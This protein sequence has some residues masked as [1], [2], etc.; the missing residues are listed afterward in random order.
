MTQTIVITSGKRGVGKTY[1]SVNTAI[2]L[3]RR[4]YRTCLFDADMGLANVNILL[5]IN[6]EYSFDDY[7]FG[8]KILDEIVI[9]TKFGVDI[10]PG[11]SDIEQMVNLNR[12]EVADQVTSLSPIKGYDY[13]LIDTSSGISRGVIAFCL[14]SNQTIIVI[15]SEATSLKDA[16]ALLKVMALNNYTGTVKIL[17]N[18]SPSIAQ[19]KETYLHF[20]EVANRH[21]KINIVPAGII[22]NDPH[23]EISVIHQEPALSLFPDSLASQCIRALV[24]NIIKD[25]TR[26]H[27]EDDFS[28]FWQRYFDFSF[29][30]PSL[31]LS[32]PATQVT[33]NNHSIPKIP[34]IPKNPFLQNSHEGDNPLPPA[35]PSVELIHSKDERSPD[36]LPKTIVP[37]AQNGGIFEVSNLASPTPLLAK[38]L[39]LQARGELTQE[40]LLEIVSCDPVL[41]VKTLQ[42]TCATS[43]ATRQTK[44]IITRQQLAQELGTEQLTKLLSTTTMQR[45]LFHQMPAATS[46]LATSFWGHSY[47]SALLAESIAKV[48]AYPFPE[49]AFIAGLIHD[50]GRL[51]LQTDHPEVYAQFPKTIHHD[52]ALLDTERQIFG[53]SH[54][55]IGATALRSWNL[56]SFLVDAVQYHNESLSSIETAFS[57]VKIV[58][59]ACRLAQSQEVD[60]ETITLAETLFGLSASQLQDLRST[61]GEKTRQLANQFHIPLVEETGDDKTEKT[62]TRFKRQAMD[63]TLLQGALPNIPCAQELPEMI[64]S[65]FQAF[66]ILFSFSPA[67]C[68]MPDSHRTY[69][70]AIEYPD[71]FHQGTLT[72]IK[73]SLKWKK[74]PV[75]Q[76]FTSGKMIT[77]IEGE[78]S[79]ISPLADSQL[80]RAL[81]T[82]GLAC[83]PMAAHGTNR[84]VIVFGIPETQR[85][86]IHSLRD[87]LEQFGTQ[88]ARN[89]YS[90]EKV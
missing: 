45:A 8:N 75:V 64:R 78:S 56:D 82:Q 34:S 79:E 86:K 17:V 5:G 32:Q 30:V 63:Y 50:I 21:L 39:K 83:V 84:G 69:L 20:K 68:L 35:V 71:C 70:K 33:P 44:R 81:G 7:I 4:N 24:S 62:E 76:S 12:K 6:P 40:T 38:A 26:G 73:F 2:E 77:A 3:A 89:I 48:T 28:E 65:V 49:E 22:L 60:I 58:F 10:I 19:A 72:D 43:R 11:S 61:A 85:D 23:I 53:T 36:L 27:T 13:L 67:L 41:M 55:E 31:N 46:K 14:A 52:K 9:E 29:L 18:K 16:Y 15:T 80:L 54:A 87:R 42:I 59:L 57:L 47:T 66:K 74:S 37:F 88:A 25:K 1:I 90:Q 51:A